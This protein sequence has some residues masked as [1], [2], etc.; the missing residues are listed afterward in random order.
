MRATARGQIEVVDLNHSELTFARRFL[1]QRQDGSFFRRYLTNPNWPTLPDD[2]IGEIDCLLNSVIRRIVKCNIDLAF[3]LQNAKASRRR[4]EQ[5]HDRHREN[6]LT[7]V[8]LHVIEP[9]QPIYFANYRITYLRGWTLNAVQNTRLFDID[10]INHA[11]VAERARVVWLAAA[12]RIKG[13]TIERDRD[14]AVVALAHPDHTRVEFEQ[15][16]IIVVKSIGC[17]HD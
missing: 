14:L 15:A 10:T 13:S 16:R 3:V 5:F 2:L 4:V 7:S 8:L 11:R 1:T 9:S 6:V 17:S 12:G